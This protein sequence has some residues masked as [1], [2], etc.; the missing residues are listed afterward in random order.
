MYQDYKGDGSVFFSKSEYSWT[1]KCCHGK[2]TTVLS[3]DS[4]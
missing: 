3:S 1:R 4:F 2:E